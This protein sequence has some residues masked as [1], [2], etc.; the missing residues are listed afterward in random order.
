MSKLL[1]R[2]L[3]VIKPSATLAVNSKAIAL[4]N[5]GKDVIN[6]SVGEPDFDTPDF[7]KEAGYRA[8]QNGQTKYTIVDGTIELKQA[9]AAKFKRENGLEYA[10]N[11]I[12]VA[13]GGKQVLYNAFMATLNPN[14]EV[15][16]PA[17]YWTSY[18]EMVLLA[19]GKP[20][21]IETD[22]SVRFKITPQ[23]LEQAITPYTKWFL[24]T[25]P[26]NPTGVAYTKEEL[27]A[28]GEV[29]LGYPHVNIMVDDIYEHL[30]YDGFRFYTLPEVV[31]GLKERTLVINGVS[32]TFSMTGWRI[33]FAAGNPDI[34]KAMGVIQSQSTSNPC[35]IS[36][37]AAVAALNGDMTFIE[38]W[39]ES[40][41]QRRNFVCNALNEMSGI[42][43]DVP[44]GAFYVFPSIHGLVGLKTPDGQLIENDVEFAGYLIDQALVAVVP[45]VAFGAFNHMRISYVVSLHSLEIAMDRLAEAICRLK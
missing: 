21:F 25:S 9:I 11:Q 41:V 39:K 36:Q 8:I 12:T 16:I 24:L 5:Q 32:K 35:S 27:V 18:P 43:C 45:G 42:R 1:A 33:G 20:V 13:G 15:I 22:H 29:L 10:L 19:E 3:D 30:T 17:P 44:E 6:L 37:A 23:Q 28:L 26:S 34:I 31:P 38:E 40:F 4:K 7:I 14:D 2:R